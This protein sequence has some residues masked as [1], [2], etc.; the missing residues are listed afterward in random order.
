MKFDCHIQTMDLCIPESVLT[1]DELSQF[2][3]TNNEWIVERTGIRQ[4]HRIAEN[5]SASELGFRAAK[6]ALQKAGLSPRS[7]T[8][9]IVATCTPDSLSPSVACIIAGKLDA[10]P[11]MAFDV[12]A[13]CTGFIYGI[14]ICSSLL[15]ASPDSV[16]L[17][18]CTEA[19]SRRLNWKDRSTCVLFGDAAAACVITGK[20]SESLFSLEDVICE[21]DGTQT[22]LIVVGGG[23]SCQYEIGDP[24]NEC[25][26][27]SMQGRDTYKHAV[28]Q[29]VTVCETILSKNNLDIN[30]IDLFVPHQANLRIIEAVGSRLKISPDKVFTNVEN[31]GNTSAASIPLA[32]EEAMQAGRLEPGNRILLTAFGAGLTW[33]AAL[34]KYL[35]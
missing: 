32:L 15:V 25:F 24:V 26:F 23:T 8:H 17:F 30:A 33:G 9:I 16:I 28:R 20:N 7:L 2:V 22:N 27:L 29:M 34:L 6:K 5:E 10:G 3:D 31:Y 21:C 11:V 1:N 4:R 14:S 35:T 19:L 18:V 13:A 12:G